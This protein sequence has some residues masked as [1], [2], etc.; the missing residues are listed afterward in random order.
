M[1]PGFLSIGYTKVPIES[2]A[3]S[4]STVTIVLYRR[5]RHKQSSTS[6]SILMAQPL[7]INQWAKKKV[8]FYSI[9][10][11]LIKIP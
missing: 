8:N 10:F 2:L 7:T 1:T 3:P 11:E 5:K 6:E 4:V 9:I